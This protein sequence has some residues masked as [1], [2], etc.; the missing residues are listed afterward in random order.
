MKKYILARRIVLSLMLILVICIMCVPGAGEFYAARL[1]PWISLVMSWCFSIIPFSLDEWVVICGVAFLLLYPVI[2]LCRRKRVL[3]VIMDVA[4]FSVGVFVWFYLGWGCNYY[5][6]SFYE[7]AQIKMAEVDKQ[8][9]LE[10]MQMFTDSLNANYVSN[11]EFVDFDK[12]A[13]MNEVKDIYCNVPRHFGLQRPQSFQKPKYVVFNRLYSAVGVTGFMGP[14]AAESQLNDDL[15]PTQYS[16]VYAHETAHL[17]GV[18]S[19]AEANYWAYVVCRKSD[20]RLVRYSAF[21]QMLPYMLRSAYSVLSEDEYKRCYERIDKRVLGQLKDM[22]EYWN[23]QEVK[24]VADVQDL[25]YDAYLR[26]NKIQSGRK[27]YNQVVEMVMS[28][29]SS[30][31]QQGVAVE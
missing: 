18:S 16:F 7:R 23:S 12:C 15:F 17:L 1:Y 24:L 30:Q 5:R 26:C 14:F 2:A 22:S 21:Q 6:S 3:A 13:V 4:E 9:F 20:S 31:K 29:Y 10:Y 27:N 19:E 8:M 28:E 25:V 11:D